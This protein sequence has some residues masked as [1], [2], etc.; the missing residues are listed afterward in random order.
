MGGLTRARYARRGRTAGSPT[1]R[2][3]Y[4]DGV[5]VVVR[6]R[7]NRSHGEGAQVVSDARRREACVMQAS[8]AR[9]AQPSRT[10]A[11]AQVRSKHLQCTPER[12]ILPM[13]GSQAAAGLATN[14]LKL[15]TVN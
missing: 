12:T 6:G 7:E 4:G 1:G 3:P 11:D 10:Y 13:S 14:N 8:R 2:E 5:P 9:A 15:V